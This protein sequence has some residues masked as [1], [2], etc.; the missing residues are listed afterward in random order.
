VL[1]LTKNP[2]TIADRRFILALIQPPHL[3]R[4][5]RAGGGNEEFAH[6][7]SILGYGN[8]STLGLL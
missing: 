5:A 7:D 2:K 4:R 3:S 1:A 6:M 8:G